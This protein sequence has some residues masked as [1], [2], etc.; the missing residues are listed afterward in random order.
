MLGEVGDGVRNI[1]ILIYTYIIMAVSED[2][3]KN[4]RRTKRH[5]PHKYKKSR[6]LVKNR[7]T[8]RR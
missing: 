4:S 5:R 6:R 7:Q 8:R 2:Y 1:L 3:A